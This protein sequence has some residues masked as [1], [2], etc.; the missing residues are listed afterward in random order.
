M[1]GMDLGE[2]QLIMLFPLSLS[3]VAQSWFATIDASCKLT[4]EDLAH[5][6]IQQISFNTIIDVTRRELEAMRHGAHETTTSFISC[7]RE[8]AI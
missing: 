3:S 5:E 6:F 8:K 7:W 1:R 2:T 4:W